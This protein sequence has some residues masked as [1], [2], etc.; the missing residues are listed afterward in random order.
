MRVS[1]GFKTLSYPAHPTVRMHLQAP[2]PHPQ[3]ASGE[4]LGFACDSCPIGPAESQDSCSMGS[5]TMSLK[6]SWDC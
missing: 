1:I 4:G 6:G 5:S 2:D 3:A